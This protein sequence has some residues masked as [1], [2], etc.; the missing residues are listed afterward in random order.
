MSREV[1]TSEEMTRTAVRVHHAR[2]LIA[3]ALGAGVAAVYW[4]V[5]D[6]LYLVPAALVAYRLHLTALARYSGRHTALATCPTCARLTGRGR[7][8]FAVNKMLVWYFHRRIWDSKAA[9]ALVAI[10]VIVTV[11]SYALGKPHALLPFV[12]TFELFMMQFAL[13][14]RSLVVHRGNER[15]CRLCI[16]GDEMFPYGRVQESKT[17]G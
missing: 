4:L 16:Q 13:L 8:K 7:I 11:I 12:V 1:K 14:F 17:D 6:S 2:P 10:G 15:A 3:L 9:M 5:G